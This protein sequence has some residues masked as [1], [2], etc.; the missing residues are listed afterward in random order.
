MTPDAAAWSLATLSE[1]QDVMATGV[2]E[3]TGLCEAHGWECILIAGSALGAYRHQDFI[4]WDDDVD[5]ALPIEHFDQLCELASRELSEDMLL[6]TRVQDKVLGADAKLY[7]NNTKVQDLFGERHN[8][9]PPLDQGLFVDIF[10]LCPLARSRIVRRFEVSLARLC[11]VRPQ[12]GAL[13]SSRLM[14]RQSRLIYT[15]I[16]LVPARLVDKARSW[17]WRRARN[18]PEARLVGI[19]IAGVNG[20]GPFRVDELLPGTPVQFH[21]LRAHVPREIGKFLAQSYGDDY[22]TPRRTNDGHSGRIYVLGQ[23]WSGRG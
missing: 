6:R 10:A 19:G 15:S 5:L 1:A 2:G 22:D 14:P 9:I 17:L 3:L 23:R 20:R 11:Y 4:P 21:S 18:R 7:F 12:A 16:S 8:L 13:R